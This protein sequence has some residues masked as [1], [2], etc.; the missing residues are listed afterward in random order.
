M[1]RQV[2]DDEAD[3]LRAEVR[4]FLARRPDLTPLDLVHY[5][6]LSDCAGRNFVSGHLP[7]GRQVI[8]EFRR[9]LALAKAGDI[10]TP[11]GGN[12]VVVRAETPE[13]VRR[14]ARRKTSYQTE[15]VRRVAEVLDFATEHATIGVITADFGAGKSH[16][17][18]EYRRTHGHQELLVFEFD[19]FSSSNKV[20][21]VQQL[22]EMLGL[23]SAAGQ[24]Y[25][26]RVF[27]RVCET[28]RERPCL[29][30]FDQ[31]E[32]VRAAVLQV[33]RQIWDR[34]NDA[35]VGMVLLAAPVLLARMT[36]SRTADLGALTSRV[37]VWAPLAGV[38][39][40]E[41][42]AIVKQEGVS[43]V[44]EDAF[45][46]WSRAVGGSMRRLMRSLDLLKAKHAGKRVTRATVVGMA[47]HLWGLSMPG[48]A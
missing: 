1:T 17:L 19:E 30:V 2:A 20:H 32:V 47:G 9:V 12:G 14:V 42:A 35:G 18:Q 3:A 38:S 13:R 11:G 23:E 37:G 44:A 46:L 36:V 24:Q 33:V 27:R 10:L 5:T 39:R 48:E 26:G 6:T 40:A 15:F 34:T 43:D 4:E 31:C 16:A 25:G 7:G 21:F 41:M 45:E 29:I 22:A 8:G 28:L